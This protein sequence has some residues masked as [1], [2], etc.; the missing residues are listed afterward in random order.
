MKELPFEFA[1]GLTREEYIRSQQ[2]ME[3]GIGAVRWIFLTFAAILVSLP[4]A[5]WIVTKQIDAAFWAFTLLIGVAAAAMGMTV[6]K[7]FRE[8]HGDS[9]DQ[10]LFGGYCFDGVVTVTET[11]IAKATPSGE[12]VIPFGSCWYMETEEMMIFRN[13]H[14]K[15]I[16]L[17]SRYLTETDAQ[18]IRELALQCVPSP[19]RV[20]KQRLKAKLTERLPLP[21][22]DKSL[23][24]EAEVSVA[25]EYTEKEFKSLLVDSIFAA[26]PRS[27]PGKVLFAAGLSSLAIDVS[28][29]AMAGVFLLAAVAL[30][31]WPLITVG[32]KV[33]RALDATDGSVLR[34]TAEL[35]PSFLRLV[36]AG[37][38]GRTLQIPW[39][40]ITRAIEWPD[41]VELFTTKKLVS[42]PKRHISDIDAFRTV[43][44]RHL[45]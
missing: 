13:P 43:I 40:R 9:Y 37:E 15:S 33:R 36:G 21:S 5:D 14:G 32:R 30:I 3:R 18:T 42:I 12:S 19:H 27:I 39:D 41:R 17:P 29:A 26:I 28:P 6:P 1:V 4:V 45:P 31:F 10:T 35:T 11:Q 22:L 34:V 2:V 8:R 16:I 7:Q 25:V 24:E 44:D 23:P 20:L 38:Q